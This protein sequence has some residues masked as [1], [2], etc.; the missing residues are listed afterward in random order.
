[1]VYRTLLATLIAILTSVGADAQ[2]RLTV[3]GCVTA[4]DPQADPDALLLTRAQVTENEPRA[5]GSNSAKSST[6]LGGAP[7][8]TRSSA[9][10][11]NTP[12]GSTPVRTV[13]APDDAVASTNATTAKASVSVP[14]KPPATSTYVLD[15]ASSLSSLTGRTV[16][17]LGSM[18]AGSSAAAA[19]MLRVERVRTLAS[20]CAS[21]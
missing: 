19:P 3:V 1:M 2:Q 17:I 6:P 20:S 14:R 18:L 4:G 10:G 16:E 15:A 13:L 5:H 7:A 12:K 8:T 21:R 11:S 9:S